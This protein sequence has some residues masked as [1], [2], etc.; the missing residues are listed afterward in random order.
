MKI[1]IPIED[2]ILEIDGRQVT[3]TI[4]GL[5]R[6]TTVSDVDA[7]SIGMVLFPT[8]PAPETCGTTEAT[9]CGT[10]CC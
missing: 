8:F 2:A 6:S 4:G 5:T 9:K 10:E 1:D 3:M 7:I